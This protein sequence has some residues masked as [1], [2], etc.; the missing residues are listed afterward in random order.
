MKKVRIAK[1]ED[2]EQIAKLYSTSFSEHILVQRGILNNPKYLAKRLQNPDEIWA[3]EEKDGKIRGIA[4]LAVCL[5]IGLG[6]I[7]RVCVETEQ[8]G[9][10]ISYSICNFLVD[11][12]KDL[13]LGFVEAFARGD[14]PAMQRT[15]EKLG[16]GVY[17]VSPRFE[18]VHNDK[19]VREQ[20][21]NMGLELKP[22]TID[23]RKMNLIPKAQE[24]YNL[25]HNRR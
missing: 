7:E 9:K 10:G 3:V 24:V 6:E 14:E 18:I 22:E 20:F 19:V 25:T 17:G 16:F 23:E 13:D 21:V 11:K 12:A 4:A 1:L 15:F 2:V 5:P 8:R